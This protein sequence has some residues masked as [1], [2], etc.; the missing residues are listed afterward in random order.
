[1]AAKTRKRSD[2]KFFHKTFILRF[3]LNS[4]LSDE[5]LSFK[6]CL[7]VL[8]SPLS[9]PRYVMYK[10]LKEALAR[11]KNLKNR[12]GLEGFKSLLVKSF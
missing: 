3:H 8:C 5:K 4:L 11:K 6:L 12:Q 7:F 10:T 9:F 2:L 1:M